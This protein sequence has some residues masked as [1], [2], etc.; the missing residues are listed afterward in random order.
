MYFYK[1]K[2]HDLDATH[3]QVSSL[4]K[5]TLSNCFLQYNIKILEPIEIINYDYIKGYPDY[6]TSISHTK[7]FHAVVISEKSKII[8][9]GIDIEL[10]DRKVK[11][12][13]A[14]RISHPKDEYQNNELLNFWTQKEAAFKALSPIKTTNIKTLNDLWVRDLN[15]GIE[16]KVIGKIMTKKI[17]NQGNDITLSIATI[18]K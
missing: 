9:I 6:C 12:E 3:K 15:F 17:I 10:S 16:E 13:I 8:S 2:E 7:G 11:N 5:E 14:S 18:Y 1:L 4:S